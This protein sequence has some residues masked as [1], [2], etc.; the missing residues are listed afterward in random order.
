MHSEVC[1]WAKV[2]RSRFLLANGFNSFTRTF[3]LVCKISVFGIFSH[4]STRHCQLSPNFGKKFAPVPCQLVLIKK[5]NLC[6]RFLFHLCD[7]FNFFL[8]L[9]CLLFDSYFF[10][11]SRKF[12]SYYEVKFKL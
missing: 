9:S 8:Q 10:P 11:I 4:L 1:D 3:F 7:P 2:H 12:H 6:K 5:Q